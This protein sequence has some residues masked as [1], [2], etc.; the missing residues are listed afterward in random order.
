[1]LYTPPFLLLQARL[2]HVPLWLSHRCGFGQEWSSQNRLCRLRDWTGSSLWWAVPR[3]P[4][5][6]PELPVHPRSSAFCLF[7]PVLL[8]FT[9]RRS[10]MIGHR[11]GYWNGYWFAQIGRRHTLLADLEARRS[12]QKDGDWAQASSAEPRLST[13]CSSNSKRCPNNIFN[14]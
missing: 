6:S 8:R 12:Y 13:R 9:D 10:A 2:H 7:A 5:L 4:L 14:I 1:M 3:W 11:P